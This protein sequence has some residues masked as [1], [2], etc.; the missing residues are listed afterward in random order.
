MPHLVRVLDTQAWLVEFAPWSTHKKSDME[1]SICSPS[2]AMVRWVQRKENC[3]EAKGPASWSMQCKRNSKRDLT[4]KHGGRREHLPKVVVWLPY[5]HQGVH[6]PELTHTHTII[7][8]HQTH[9]L[10]L[11]LSLLLLLKLKTCSEVHF[12]GD[13]RS[14]KSTISHVLK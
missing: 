13:S 9:K 10:L 2:T 8:T 12:L 11:L 1:V 5:M 3:L 7:I 14:V 6:M 4:S